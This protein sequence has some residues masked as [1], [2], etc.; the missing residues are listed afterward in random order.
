L[1]GN[2]NDAGL[3]ELT[4]FIGIAVMHDDHLWSFAN[5]ASIDNFILCLKAEETAR[6]ICDGVD[7]AIGICGFHKF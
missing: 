6:C 1:E 2:G 7:N 3:G 4:N 5:E